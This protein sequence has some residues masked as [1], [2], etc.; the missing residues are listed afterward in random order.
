MIAKIDEDVFIDIDQI[1]FIKGD[2]SPTNNP[3][4]WFT[5]I[6]VGGVIYEI[7]GK[8]GKAVMDAFL[9]KHSNAIYDMREGR[10]S[11]KQTITRGE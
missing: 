5:T 2:Y 3:Y 8:S 7:K 9:W 11:Y 6:I 1:T 10:P 4:M